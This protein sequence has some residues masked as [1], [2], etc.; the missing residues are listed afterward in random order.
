MINELPVE[1]LRNV[2]D[3]HALQCEST[4]TVSP[5]KEIFG[6]KRAVNALKFGLDI[7]EKGFNVY[8]AGAPGTGKT[9]AVKNYLDEMAKVQPVPYDWCYVYN[10]R[11]SYH[12][13]ALRLQPGSGKE[14][15]KDMESLLRS[16]ERYT[17]SLRQGLPN[18]DQFSNRYAKTKDSKLSQSLR[19]RFPK[20][21]ATDT[22]WTSLFPW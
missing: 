21:H 20:L 15:R 2:V 10:F 11:D 6:Q 9:T 22:P 5:M 13:K 3:P 18:Q 16:E 12:P 17:W 7:K 4:D 8:A 19:R 1:K 14:L